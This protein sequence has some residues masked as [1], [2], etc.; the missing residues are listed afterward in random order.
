MRI[1]ALAALVALL[2]GCSSE[3]K[4]ADGKTAGTTTDTPTSTTTATG[5]ATGTT[6][7]TTPTTGTTTTPTDPCVETDVVRFVALGDAGTGSADQLAVADAM[8]QVCNTRC[9][10]FA[11]YLG[12]NFYNSGVDGADD[13]LFIDYFEVP[14][15]NLDFPFYAALGNHD[16]GAEGLGIEF[17]KGNYYLDYAQNYTTKFTFPDL[18]YD[19]QYEHVKFMALNTTEIFF[20][21]TQQ[22]GTW[23]DDQMA[24]LDP[25]VQWVIG[26]GHH[27]YISNGRHG[28][29]GTYEGI[30]LIPIVSGGAVR[31]F[32][33]DHMCGQVDIYFSGHDHNRQ[34]LEPTCGTE[35][36]VSGAG[37][38][39]TDL[40]G[41]GNP[42]FFEDDTIEGFIWMEIRGGTFTTAFY[43]KNA[44]LEYEQ[45]FTP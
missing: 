32:F 17:W 42:A 16:Y 41:R 23:V 37:A 22:Q 38:K 27:P 31:D 44:T 15:A 45:V 36:I 39:T 30:P 11:L 9:C 10:D 13:D 18:Y 40:E 29:A 3:N 12:D 8:E 26:F 1:T 25:S 7:T 33:D 2:G 20:G 5:T 4:V 19:F 14:Y 35:F 34:L 6:A 28:N 24:N 43:D 21:L